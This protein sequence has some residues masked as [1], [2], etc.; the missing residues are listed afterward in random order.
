V[1]RIIVIGA[2]V[3][4]LTTASVLARDGHDVTVLERDPSPP[5]TSADAAWSGWERRGVN[6]FRMLHFFLPRFR[7]LL[8]AELP[9][10]VGVA[11]G[12]GAL[13]HN[14]IALA[15]PEVT[16]G[17]RPGDEQFEALTARR[18]VMEAAL[19]R[20][21]ESTD[22]V[23]IRRGLAVA[24]LAVGEPTAP[25]VPHVVG[26]RTDAGEDLDAD[27][28][29]DASGR[30]SPLPGWLAA[31]DARAPEEEIEDSGFV[32]YGRYFRSV[33]GTL[34]FAFGPPLQHYDSVS[35]LTLPA[36]NGTWG[37]GFITSARD[38]AVRGLRDVSRWSAALKRYP[39]VAHWGDGEPLDDEVAVMAKIA[40]RHRSFVVDGTPVVTGVIAIAD[41]WA[42]TNPSVGRGAS[43]GFLHVVALRNLLRDHPLD[44]ALG[45]AAEWHDATLREVEPW[46]RSTLTFDRHRLAEIEAQTRGEP[47]DTDDPQWEITHAMEHAS[48][49]DPDILR[50]V[51]RIAG[52]LASPDEVL[53]APGFLDRVVELGAG[54][55]DAPGAGPDRAE[56]LATLAS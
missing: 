34:P 54:W 10:A 7:A 25:G 24:G 32:Y 16:G 49:Q 51:V 4:G 20:V 38:A 2:G 5:P 30:R 1:A 43:I 55:R 31:I 23:T 3:G 29:V 12:F 21:A 18:P 42:C 9:E 19:A 6:Q 22:G 41:A 26:V 8:D 11:E 27:L 15:P 53:G 39:L 33:D 14:S 13:R 45:F 17:P 37:V 28:V 46:Y 35:V 36:D 50:G 47:Y 40:D 44:D 56:L 52:L 48:L